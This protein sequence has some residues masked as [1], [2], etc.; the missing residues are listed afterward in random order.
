MENKKTFLVN[1][2]SIKAARVKKGF[3]SRRA[4]A[5]HLG[6]LGI[7]TLSRCE[8]SPQKP[9]RAYLNTL[10]ILSDALDVSPE[11]LI[12]DDTDLETGNKLAIRDCSGIWQVIGQ[13]IVVKEH[14]DYPNGPKKI[15]AKIEI[16]VDLEKCK[17]FATGYDH[18]NDPLHFEGS[19]YENGNHIV[20]EYFV[21]N[22]RLHVYGTLNLQY[23][24]CGKRMSGYYVGRETGQ[25]TTYI[26]GNLVMELKEK[27]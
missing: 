10:K 13:D 1:G 15:E 27:L 11:N 3:L 2:S 18:D 9:H 14:F 22:D 17:I 19:I 23:H 26:L 12:I 24:G 6:S 16:K 5:D 25:G 20:G 21:K 7:D 8:K 4:F